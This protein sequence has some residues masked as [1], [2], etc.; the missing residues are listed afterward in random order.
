MRD[1]RK[2]AV[3]TTVTEWDEHHR[4]ERRNGI[5]DVR[6]IDLGDLTDHHATHLKQS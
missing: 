6:P 3:G 4:D 2:Q 5:P 1:S